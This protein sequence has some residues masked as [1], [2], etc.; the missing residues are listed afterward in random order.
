[1]K[2]PSI[3]DFI[4]EGFSLQSAFISLGGLSVTLRLTGWKLGFEQMNCDIL[5]YKAQGIMIMI[6]PSDKSEFLQYLAEKEGV[7]LN[8]EFGNFG[9]WSKLTFPLSI[10]SGLKIKAAF[11]EY[12]QKHAKPSRPH[13]PDEVNKIGALNWFKKLFGK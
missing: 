7:S 2:T 1:M 9:M 3:D 13:N 5:Y 10:E 11:F 4:M 6:K 8:I 12:Y